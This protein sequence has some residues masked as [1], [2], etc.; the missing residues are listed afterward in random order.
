M[1]TSAI[2][3]ALAFAQAALAH[4]SIYGVWVNGEWQGDG[5]ELYVGQ[6]SNSPS[7]EH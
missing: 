1:K 7:H 3:S 6:T 4:I 2:V 5:R